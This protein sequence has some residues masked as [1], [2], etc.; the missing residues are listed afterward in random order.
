MIGKLIFRLPE[1]SEAFLDAQRASA[2]KAAIEDIYQKVFRPM[3]KHGY[4][5]EKLQSLIES[6]EDVR[7]AIDKLREL[8]FEVLQDYDIE[9]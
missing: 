5:D 6:N 9:G 1:E 3:H 7:E 4:V 8:Y 2:Y